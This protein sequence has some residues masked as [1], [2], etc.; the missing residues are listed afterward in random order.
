MKPDQK[1]EL[2]RAA[3]EVL[4]NRFPAALPLGGIRRRIAADGMVDFPYSNEELEGALEFSKQE[5][6]VKSTPDPFGSSPAWAA[7]SEGV[8]ACERNW[9]K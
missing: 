3:A 8:K 7:T 5:G 9:Q 1:E 2:R 4:A 6:F